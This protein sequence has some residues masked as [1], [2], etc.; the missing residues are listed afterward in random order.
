MECP[1]STDNAVDSSGAP[2]KIEGIKSRNIWAM[3]I[4]TINTTRTSGVVNCKRKGDEINNK[5]ATRFI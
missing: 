2:R 3:A 1:G 4:A 5:R